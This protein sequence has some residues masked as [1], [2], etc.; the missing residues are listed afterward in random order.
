MADA[1]RGQAL[2]LT[3]R[4][5]ARGHD[6]EF[7]QAVALLEML[8]ARKGATPLGEGA[9]PRREG[10]V[11]GSPASLK[12]APSDVSRITG[13]EGERPRIETRVM[14]LAGQG[15]PLPDWVTEVMSLRVSRRDTAMRDFFDLFNH[16]LLSL[17]YKV[18]DKA[19]VGFGYRSPDKSPAARYLFSLMGLGTGRLQGRLG[20][21]VPDR[22]L[23]TYA[24]LLAGRTRSVGALERLLSH[25][26][27]VPVKVEPLTG[28][29]L[30]L[31]ADERT[32]L[33]RMGAHNRLGQGAMIGSRVWDVE[34]CFT[35]RIGPMGWQDVASFLPEG[36]RHQPLV[37]LTRLF[38]GDAMD[39]RLHLQV[40]KAEIPAM[41]LSSRHGARL[42]WTSILRAA[43]ETGATG[44]IRVR[45]RL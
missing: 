14:G 1:D 5:E 37:S 20:E 35:L 12:F 33:G 23:L 42:G 16:R 17:F 39:F 26:L 4:L 31:D 8:A 29:W 45:P 9:D 21:K 6:Y 40:K 24:G 2:G 44:D 41:Q 25:A 15:G 11:L 32:R 30:T 18:R 22:M 27:A 7:F 43:N 34:S 38:V 19:R 28:R 10:L 3:A 13:V 36:A